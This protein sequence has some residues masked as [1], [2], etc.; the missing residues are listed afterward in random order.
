MWRRI[1]MGSAS[2]ATSGALACSIVRW[3]HESFAEGAEGG[4]PG[5]TV[6]DYDLYIRKPKVEDLKVLVAEFERGLEVWPWVWLWRNKNGPHHVFVGVNKNVKKRIEELATDR[7]NNI[8]L[9]D[10]MQERSKFATDDF[11]HKN[12][13]AIVENEI[14]LFD[15]M[16]KILMLD[17]ERVTCFDE[18]TIVARTPPGCPNGERHDE[19]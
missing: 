14:A 3:Q 10:A 2:F 9:I 17:D 11:Y 18:C 15:P 5:Q 1:L 8:L 16:S 7:K 12:R 13:C 6:A 19:E 4:F